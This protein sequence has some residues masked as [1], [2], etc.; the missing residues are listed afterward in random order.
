MTE[1][2]SIIISLQPRLNIYVVCIAYNSE[3]IDN[4]CANLTKDEQQLV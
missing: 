4:I 3:N 2:L 1:Y